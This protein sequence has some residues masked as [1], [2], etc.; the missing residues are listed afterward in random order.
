MRKIISVFVVCIIIALV[1][2]SGGSS[3]HEGE[4]KTPS[5]SS[6]QEGKDY[7]EV[8]KEFKDR[9]FNNINTK[10]QEDLIT[11]WLT[12][13][14]EVESVS[15]D[16]DKDYSANEWYSDDVKVVITYHTFPEEEE[17]S[18]TKSA[19]KKSTENK[20]TKDPSTKSGK[21]VLTAENNNDLKALLT[22]EDETSPIFADFAKK[23]KGRTIEFDGY[24]ANMML[25]G[26]YKTRYNILML[27][28]DYGDTTFRGPNF[29]F[30]NVNIVHELNLEG[31]N[32]PDTIGTGQNLHIKAEVLEYDDDPGLFKLKPVSTEFR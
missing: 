3:G 2:C 6:V 19:D 13:D 24:I 9:G 8:I 30:E 31:S 4:A 10:K 26:N 25:H 18:K 14:G 17:K 23:Y 21:E 16:G 27:V 15:V 11:A 20:S 22:V 28:G 12:K 1:G 5:G 29:Q 7:K 32:I